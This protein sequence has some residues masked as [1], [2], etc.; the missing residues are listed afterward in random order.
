MKKAVIYGGGNIGRGFIGQ[1]FYESGYETAF[2]DINKE[3]INQLN[4]KREYPVKFTDNEPEIIIKN[5]RGIDGENHA[6]IADAVA[7]ADINGAVIS[8]FSTKS[9]D[10]ADIFTDERIIR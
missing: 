2:I 6:E 4:E 5:I 10:E 1:L 3:L 8:E 9:V 7:E